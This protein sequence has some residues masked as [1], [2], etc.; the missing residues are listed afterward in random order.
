MEYAYY[1]HACVQ[2]QLVGKC[3]VELCTKHACITPPATSYE[4]HSSPTSF[5]VV[6][7][8]AAPC[9]FF[10]PRMPWEVSIRRAAHCSEADSSLILPTSSVSTHARCAIYIYLGHWLI[11]WCNIVT[12]TSG[13]WVIILWACAISKN[14][15]L[16]LWSRYLFEINYTLGVHFSNVC[17]NL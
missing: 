6:Y 14:S 13:E 3:R 12:M 15:S 8:L 16:V 11:K 5:R 2:T 1:V 10:F 7:N 4:T 17:C 9:F